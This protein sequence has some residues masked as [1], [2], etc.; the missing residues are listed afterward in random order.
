MSNEIEV[1]DYIIE[2]DKDDILKIEEE[3]NNVR[4]HGK[5]NI[6]K[7]HKFIGENINAQSGWISVKDRLPTEES[8]TIGS[9]VRNKL[10][11]VCNN[12]GIRYIAKF[13]KNPMYGSHENIFICNSNGKMLTKII[14]WMPLPEPPK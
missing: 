5:E 7:L 3:Y 6:E 2:Y 8:E 9:T 14:L 13:R 1:D 4:I 10:Y 11:I 12:K